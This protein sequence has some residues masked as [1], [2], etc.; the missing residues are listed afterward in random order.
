V[1]IARQFAVPLIGPPASDVFAEPAPVLVARCL[2][3]AI[4]FF[5]GLPGGREQTLLSA[6]RA[7]GWAVDGIWRSKGDS[8]RLV[9]TR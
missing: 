6:C 5:S 9:S 3:E 1:S 2:L 7:W 4:D 8:A